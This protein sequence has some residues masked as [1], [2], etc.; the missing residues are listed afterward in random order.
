MVPI[1]PLRRNRFYYRQGLLAVALHA[2]LP[3]AQKP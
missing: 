1:R 3:L 2:S